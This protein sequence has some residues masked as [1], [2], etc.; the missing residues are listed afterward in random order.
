MFFFN[1][2]NIRKVFRDKTLHLALFL[3]SCGLR[4][5][6]FLLFQSHEELPANNVSIDL[7]KQVHGVYRLG[8]FSKSLAVI[9]CIFRVQEYYFTERRLRFRE[10]D[11]ITP[12][13][14]AIVTCSRSLSVLH[15]MMRSL[16]KEVHV[17][18]IRKEK[19]AL[20]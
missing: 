14:T 9:I 7:V 2:S 16:I 13:H 17:E 12:G 1:F 6:Q 8:G 11:G 5:P 15:K 18:E 3:L 10:E 19:F 20:L 4:C